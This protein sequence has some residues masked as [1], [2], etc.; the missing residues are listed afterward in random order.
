MR[1]LILFFVLVM[2]A[3]LFTS[4]PI[5]SSSR[6]FQSIWNTGH[7]FLF[8]GLIWLLMTQTALR[9]LN[10][11][12]MY[13]TSIV[14]AV[15]L[16]GTIEVL[17]FFVGRSVSFDDILLDVLGAT[18][19]FLWVQFSLPTERNP[20]SKPV[21]L[22]LG[23]LCIGLTF[24]PVLQVL[25]VNMQLEERLPVIANFETESSLDFWIK[26]SISE[27]E[28][29]DVLFKE[30]KS[31][32]RIKFKA[33]EYPD[34]TLEVLA[35]DWTAYRDLNFSI[36]ND[37]KESIEVV[38]KIYDR[39]HRKRGY[40]HN[41]RFNDSVQ[42][43]PGWNEIKIKL[44]DV[45]DSPKERKMDLSDIMGISLFMINPVT[46]QSIHLDNIYLSK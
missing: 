25:R 32:V 13:A 6:L 1:L 26:R 43:N 38:I 15:V 29:D 36:N 18:L 7:L 27:F 35:P 14:F 5:D 8:A 4:T 12:K 16:G 31:S 10:R 3:F 41:D 22:L 11:F 21:V 37:Q 30:G 42:L 39:L 17:Q 45:Y 34:V 2:G 28:R 23:A 9:R 20:V 19:G 46:E 40:Q 44:L 24:M 33:V